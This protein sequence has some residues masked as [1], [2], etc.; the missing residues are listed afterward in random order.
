VRVAREPLL[1]LP[2]G[3]VSCLLADI[4]GSVRSWQEDPDGMREAISVYDNIVE[5]AITKRRGA[6][7]KDQGEG[8]SFFA[9]FSRASDAVECALEI[10]LALTKLDMAGPKLKVR[11]AIHTGEVQHRDEG[12][13]AGATINRCARL[14]GIG[15]GGQTL[16][17]QSTYELVVDRVQDGTWTKDLGVHRFRD[18]ARPEHVYQLCHPGLPDE[19]QSL[20]SLDS[21][22]NNLPIQLTSF[23]GREDELGELGRV[24]SASRVLT[25]SGGGGCGKTR[26]AAEM[27]AAAAE[28][29]PDG[30]W[31]VE[32]ANLGMGAAVPDAAMAAI[33]IDDAHG[34]SPT[35]RLALHLAQSKALLILDNCEHVLDG[36]AQMVEALSQGC[37]NLTVLTTSREAI[38][39]AG[40]SVWRVA[41][42]SL[43]QNGKASS[44]ESL[45]AFDAVRLFIDRAEYARPNFRVNNENAP[46]VAEIC[47]RL[48][49]IPLAIELAAARVRMMSVERILAAVADDRFHLL[50][51]GPGNSS[52][53]QGTLLASVKWS[54]DLLSDNERTLLAR[55]S[56][57]A[58]DFELDA[59]EQVC[60]DDDLNSIEVLDLL[61]QLV[62][63]SLVSFDDMHGGRYDL[64]QSIRQFAAERLVEAN[65]SEATRNRHLAFFFALAEELEPELERSNSVSLLDRFEAERANFHAALGW[66]L[67]SGDADSALK[68][69]GSLATF[70]VL[71]GHYWE[72][73][74]WLKRA[75]DAPG[76]VRAESRMRALWGLGH[77]SFFGMDLESGFGLPATAEALELAR[78]LDDKRIL[79]RSLAGLFGPEL[80]L[81]PEAG[82]AHLDEAIAVAKQTGDDWGL[83]STLLGRV[84]N[85]SFLEERHAEAVPIL[86]ELLGL[87]AKMENRRLLAVCE[88]GAGL[89][90]L[91][92]GSFRE[93]RPHLEAALAIARDIAEPTLEMF[94][95]MFLADLEISEGHYDAVHRLVDESG[96]RLRASA[97][98]RIELLE[99][100]LASVLLAEGDVTNARVLGEKVLLRF[101]QMGMPNFVAPADIL[102]GQLC[103]EAGELGDA[104]KYLEEALAIG[105]MLNVAWITQRALHFLGRVTRAEENFDKSEDIHHQAIAIQLDHGFLP[106]LMDSLDATAGLAI[107]GESWAEGLRLY[108]ACTIAREGIGSVRSVIEEGNFKSDLEAART[109]L[110][111]EAFGAA[112]AEG[113]LLS[114]EQAISY[115]SRARG[116]RRR[117]SFGWASL[118]PT[119]TEVV[120]LASQGLTNPEI[121]E[122]LFISRST[123]K[124]H[125]GH[126]FT[127]LDVSTRAMLAAEAT[128]RGI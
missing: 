23:V 108:S 22:P 72:A 15:H 61:G 107:K 68:L 67:D 40:E 14:R 70:W 78:T 89:A 31:W 124:T 45:T 122:K 71:H 77:A 114:I 38:G 120:R 54:Y 39:I 41:P 94:S 43:P 24:L 123:V 2:E 7:P 96:E 19:F 34:K 86:E 46:V 18:L 33:G 126:V 6:R 60:S 75:L 113:T 37:A 66:A 12:N 88:V 109:A 81:A 82:K 49:G 1:R 105:G 111:E 104:R 62:D 90:D 115:A 5:E 50:T 59:A 110:G 117:P 103:S 64:L 95:A 35:E 8:D 42:L 119:E 51:G 101:Q 9:A 98:G 116:E 52:A 53:R 118:T 48:D 47:A 57:F 30:V 97:R 28:L 100:R 83:A 127:K 125:L 58:G 3:T 112:S 65:A 106:D 29:Y 11:M 102:L 80:F 121:A 128:R 85:V 99:L 32:L 87:A 17:S 25:L 56:V 13:Y 69:S 10:Q 36:C 92:F 76:P 74:S 20:K 16:I 79:T 27:A 21:F 91:R 55:L 84:L 73:Q 26:L 4:E 44:P 93:A 63:K